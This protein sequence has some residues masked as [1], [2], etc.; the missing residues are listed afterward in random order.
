MEANHKTDS[1]DD[2]PIFQAFKKTWTDAACARIGADPSWLSREF[3][4]G[5]RARVRVIG[6]RKK[7]ATF[8]VLDLSNYRVLTMSADSVRTAMGERDAEKDRADWA[9]NVARHPGLRPDDLGR[10]FRASRCLYEIL[11]IRTPDQASGLC[12]VPVLCKRV[13]DDSLHVFDARRVVERL[14]RVKRE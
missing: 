6:I 3:S 7:S 13:S 11:T 5:K 4:R 10:R 14:E 2:E 12:D 9:A 8:A 1:D